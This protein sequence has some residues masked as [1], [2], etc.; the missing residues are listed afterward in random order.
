MKNNIKLFISEIK[1]IW[2]DGCFYIDSKGNEFIKFNYNDLTGIDL[3]RRTG[4]D[5]LLISADKNLAEEKAVE[6]ISLLNFKNDLKNKEKFI[7]DYLKKNN[8]KWEETAY[9]GS[10]KD[11][12]NLLKK[13]GLSATPVSAPFYVKNIARWT[14]RRGGG[15]GV[16]SEFVE[17]YLEE[18]GLLKKS[19]FLD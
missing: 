12:L 19:L 5:F 16:F 2:T 10:T 11:D 6:K 9:I 13:V 1:G 14:M 8:I 15:E 17:D 3:L 18:V 4:I 7:A